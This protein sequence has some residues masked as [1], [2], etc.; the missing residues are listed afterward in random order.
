MGGIVK[1][2]A[3]LAVAS[4]V[5]AGPV[6]AQLASHPSGE[7]GTAARTERRGI[8]LGLAGDIGAQLASSLDAALGY[9]A[10]VKIGYAINRQIQLYVAGA[11]HNAS[12]DDPRFGTFS[13]QAFLTTV[14]L[15]HFLYLERSGLGVFYDAGV[16]LG[17]ARPGF[18][19]PFPNGKTGIGL[20]Y[21]GGLGVEIPLTRYFSLVP[22]FYY[23]SVNA[24][25]AGFSGTIS[26]LGLQ[27]G[28]VYY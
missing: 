17:F 26:V 16:G 1:A 25:T 10:Q 27:L 7:G 22:E 12:Y 2:G 6:R 9:G 11:V 24:S 20:A 13:Q 3:W 18:G 8:Y 15:H 19:E 14:H 23:R 4:A 5:W 28:V 21:S